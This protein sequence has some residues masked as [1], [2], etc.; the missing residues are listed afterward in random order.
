[1]NK[2][3]N[4]IFYIFI[5]IILILF[6]I[7]FF[8]L[9]PKTSVIYGVV[10]ES[11]ESGSIIEVIDNSNLPKKYKYLDV[12]IGGLKEG[13]VIKV[14]GTID[15]DASY[16]PIVDVDS[17]D[18]ISDKTD[19]TTLTTATTTLT[20]T[21]SAVNHS[22]TSTTVK[23]T[24]KT[25]KKTTTTSK[26]VLS[27]DDKV[28]NDINYKIDDTS[29]NGD[30]K[31]FGESAKGYFVSVIDFIFYDKDINGVY[32]KDLTSSAKLKVISLALNLDNII[33]KYYPGYKEGLSSSYQGA[34]SKLISLY[35]DKTS[36]YCAS[37]V[38]V[39]NQAKSDFQELKKSLNITWD[40]IKELGSEGISKL[41][42]WYE[43][44]SGK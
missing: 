15:E 42:K 44:Y 40:F 21:T 9:K 29:K 27:N 2:K 1:M 11:S 39:C 14:V 20:T 22:A 10:R 43:V 35:L 13:D 24:K 33:D 6:F 4:I 19:A 23:T 38:D 8:Y 5:F 16:P 31:S 25:T 34:K 37:S 36:E 28:L 41:K 12:E 17:F 26:K 32:F 30:K 7:L 18:M 3:N